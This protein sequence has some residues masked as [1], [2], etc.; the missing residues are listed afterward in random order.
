MEST[1]PKL[2]IPVTQRDHAAGPLTAK[3]VIVEYGDYECPHCRLVYHDVKAL[4]EQLDERICYVFRHLPITTI[5][6]HAQIAAEAAEAAAAQG[7]F[8]EMHNALFETDDL[9]RE[10]HPGHCGRP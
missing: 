5:H 2:T 6:P 1:T 4:Q 7:K 3:V 8:W 10:K 9:S